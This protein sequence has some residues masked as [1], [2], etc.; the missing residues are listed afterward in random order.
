MF[1]ILRKKINNKII[2]IYSNVNRTT[3]FLIEANRLKT[4]TLSSN[5]YQSSVKLQN[6]MNKEIIVSLTTYG[7]RLFDVY[8]TIESI[9]QQ[10]LRPDRIILWLENELRNTTLPITLR[11]LQERGLEIRYCNDIR[12]YKKLVPTLTLFPEAIIITIDDDVLYKYDMIENLINE[13]YR[14]PNVILANR[15]RRIKLIKKSDFAPYNEWN[16]ISDEII[17]PQNVQIGVGGVLYPPHS[18]SSTV[19]DE[20]QFMKKCPSTDDLWFKV[21]SIINGVQVKRTATHEPVFLSNE[22]VQDI[23]LSLSNQGGGENDRAIRN[24]NDSYN[25]INYLLKTESCYV[26]R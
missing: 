9:F 11:L 19:I 2:D 4:I 26:V 21:M 14:Y 6:D 22:K 20:N 15:V 13:H 25:L 16:Y 17:S 5:E 12:S 23:A 1:E 24:L 3:E 7:K 8:L 18:L 10:T